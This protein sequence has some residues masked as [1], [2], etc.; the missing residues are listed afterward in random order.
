MAEAHMRACLFAGVKVAGLNA[1]VAP[2]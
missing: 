2:G 1:E